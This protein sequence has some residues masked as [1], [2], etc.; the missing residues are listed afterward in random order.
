MEQDLTLT[1]GRYILFLDIL[2]FSQLVQEKSIEDVYDTVNQTMAEFRRWEELNRDF[3]TI[4]FSDTFIFYQESK[5]YG[6]WAFLDVYA[7]GGMILSAL[8]AKGI[9]AR[10]AIS[11]GDFEVRTDESQRHQLYFGNALI[12]A[13]RAEQRENW[14]GIT[15]LKSA[16]EPFEKSKGGIVHMFERE[17]VWICR[18]DGVL[19]L[20]PFRKLIS[21]YDSLLACDFNEDEMR[22]NDCDFLNE[23]MGFKF[24][25]DRSEY[26]LKQGDFSSKVAGKYHSTVAFLKRLLGDRLYE[27]I[28]SMAMR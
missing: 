15:I 12:E 19:L 17:K 14:I 26:Y 6:D 2:G 3:R 16:W 25:H 28:Y 11:F 20:N 24:L 21:A 27:W 7:I 22:K 9:A 23:L 4:Y 18:S 10:G 1:H 13:Y 5:G 8:L